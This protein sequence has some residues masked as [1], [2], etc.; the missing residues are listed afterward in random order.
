MRNIE[1]LVKNKKKYQNVKIQRN[2]KS[3]KNSVSYVLIDGNPRILKWFVPGLKN[4]MK[5]EFKILKEGAFKLNIPTIYEKDEKNNVLI[6]NYIT[7]K[8]LSDIINNEDVSIN[9][10]QKLIV[11]L[12][13]WF[14]NFHKIFKKDNKYRLHGDANLRNF[15]FSDRLW[16]VDFEESRTGRTVEDI[17]SMCVS[18]L[19]TDPMF[20]KEKIYLC[21]NFIGSYS[22][23]APSSISNIDDEISYALLEKI[24]YRPDCEEIF[25]KHSKTIKEKGLKENEIM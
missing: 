20:T 3:K 23:Y 4:N 2:L 5:T 15:I 24:Q 10:K 18:I 11:L 1:E 17:A 6:M 21:K 13:E 14:V 7:G 12:A 22:K 8:N 16:G 9:E 25:R 19:T